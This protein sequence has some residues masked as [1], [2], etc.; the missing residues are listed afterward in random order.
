MLTFNDYMFLFIDESINSYCDATINQ[1]RP[2]WYLD[3]N[4]FNLLTTNQYIDINK[5]VIFHVR[6]S[7]GTRVPFFP[8]VGNNLYNMPIALNKII[9]TPRNSP[10]KL[11]NGQLLTGNWI[12]NIITNIYGNINISSKVNIFIDSSPSMT[13][14]SV[15]SGIIEYESIL[16]VNNIAYQRRLCESERWLRWISNTYNNARI[17]S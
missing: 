1:P 7:K 2:E 6:T 9:D 10:P 16:A 4:Q 14:N 17:C 13:I 15:L 3:L 8:F 12:D 5:I 11:V